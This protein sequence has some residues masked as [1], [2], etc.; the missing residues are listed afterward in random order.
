MFSAINAMARCLSLAGAGVE[1][2]RVGNETIKSGGAN[3][4]VGR[5]CS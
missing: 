3:W 5:V 1:F 2:W 4:F